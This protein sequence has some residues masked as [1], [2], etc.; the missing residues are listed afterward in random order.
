MIFSFQELLACENQTSSVQVWKM[1][2]PVM[3]KVDLPS[4]LSNVEKRL[5]W[6][7]EEIKSTQIAIDENEKCI[8]EVRQKV[9]ELRQ[10]A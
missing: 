7:E 4:A 6:I 1:V 8:Y 5:E 3:V 2:G 10:R 9:V